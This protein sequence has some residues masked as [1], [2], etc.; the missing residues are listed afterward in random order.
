M[1]KAF[2]SVPTAAAWALVVL[3]LGV[4]AGAW[5]QSTAPSAPRGTYGLGY[6]F[7]GFGA[8]SGGGE[9]MGT[10]HVGGGGEAVFGDAVGVGAEIGYL[11]PFESL[12]DGIGVFSVNGSYH[13]LPRQSRKLRP[14]V[15]AGYTL[16]FREGHENLW[17]FGGGV[18]YWLNQRVGIRAEFR[19]HV[20]TSGETAHLWGARIGVVFR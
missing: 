12:G 11:G 8:V 4:P 20:W 19:D 5:A 3:A 16:G 7:A 9:S 15:T 2:N 17:N 18:H 10:L 1:M 14:F 6:A 13:F